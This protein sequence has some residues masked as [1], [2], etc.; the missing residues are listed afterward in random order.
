MAR[1]VTKGRTV[2]KVVVSIAAIGYLLGRIDVGTLTEALGRIHPSTAISMLL[3]YISGQTVSALR[4]ATVLDAAGFSL[5]KDWIL[6]LY[7]GAMFF[8]LFA[9]STLGGDAVRTYTVGRDGARHTT[10]AA[11]V[12]FDRVS[13]LAML[14]L[15]GSV[16][17][18]L[19]GAPGWPPIIGWTAAAIGVGLIVGPGWVA[20]LLAGATGT[21]DRFTQRFSGP[22]SALWSS[23]RLWLRCCLLS[24]VVHLHQ[25]FAA[26]WL[27]R[28][29]GLGLPESYY[30][31]F[32]PFGIVFGALPISFSG[33]GVREVGYVWALAEM[34][35]IPS[36]TALA[37]GLAWSTLLGAAA[38]C[39]G[40]V[41]A[42]GGIK[43]QRPGR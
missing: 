27:G 9:P 24:L 15:L 4:W 30:F 28:E 12:A 7:F 42:F 3:V 32:H 35:A 16:S 2:A 41:V 40:L 34:R 25:I 5:K 31:V 20:P 1:D 8:N 33:F 14:C 21:T 38:A 26:I 6:R 23:P 18:A 39:G 11:T 13:G 43:I 10:A 37:F 29:L 17:M 19:G 22:G 36:E